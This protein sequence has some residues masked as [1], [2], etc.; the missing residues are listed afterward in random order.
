MELNL[1]VGVKHSLE[2]VVGTGESARHFGSGLVDVYATPALV[3]FLEKTSL[4]S[5]LS[6]LP[7]G[8]TSVGSEI[9]LKH[10][11]ASSLG[12]NIRSDSYLKKIEGKKVFFEWHAWDEKG[13]IGIGTHTRVIIREREFMERLK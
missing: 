4:E 9:Q 3:A 13:L 10:L 11:K 1:P 6:Y 5:I 7:E 8:Y 12:S 2:M